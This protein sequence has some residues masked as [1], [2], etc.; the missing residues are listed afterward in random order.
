MF[1][2][3]ATLLALTFAT[4]AL[5]GDYILFPRT[6]LEC[7]PPAAFLNHSHNKTAA[8]QYI[9]PNYLTGQFD[10]A[11]V[12]GLPWTCSPVVQGNS[13]TG[14][15]TIVAS[16]YYDLNATHLNT[17]EFEGVF[18]G[19]LRE[20]GRWFE[21]WYTNEGVLVYKCALPE[22]S[23][24]PMPYPYFKVVQ[25]KDAVD[26]SPITPLTVNGTSTSIS[27][28]PNVKEYIKHYTYTDSSCATDPISVSVSPIYRNCTRGPDVNFEVYLIHEVNSTTV[29]P[30]VCLDNQCQ[31][32][33]TN[34]FFY[35]DVNN[36]TVTHSEEIMQTFVR[37]ITTQCTKV[38][39][40]NSGSNLTAYYKATLEVGK[41]TG[42]SGTSD[43]GRQ[44]PVVG[45]AAL[46]AVLVG[47]AML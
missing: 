12:T 47:F 8:A 36:L 10:W 14:T 16:T 3:P 41:G 21:L 25:T 45:V 17:S 18:S 11:T 7:T 24:D 42:A 31:N 23:D 29:L 26:L 22:T 9:T 44:G 46:A 6:P 35:L 33:Q 27:P 4:H 2:T 38:E 13:T 19:W 1:T 34:S 15:A 5:A 20:V 39:G 30:K 37:N 32:C 40:G 43:A 28:D